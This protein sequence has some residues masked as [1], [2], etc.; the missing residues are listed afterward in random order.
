MQLSQSKKANI[1]SAFA[2]EMLQEI[3][4]LKP[5]LIQDF[6]DMF[7]PLINGFIACGLLTTIVS[8]VT[9]ALVPEFHSW[10]ALPIAL[11]INFLAACKGAALAY[12]KSPNRLAYVSFTKHTMQIKLLEFRGYEAQ[13]RLGNEDEKSEA[14][15]SLVACS[16]EIQKLIKTISTYTEQSTKFKN[17][18][19]GEKTLLSEALK[20]AEQTKQEIEATFTEFDPNLDKHPSISY[21][22]SVSDADHL[23]TTDVLSDRLIQE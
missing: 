12:S 22:K 14:W 23:K 21:E 9:I 1:D 15:T 20:T 10:I 4:R 3:E 16:D 7:M 17:L 13:M 11:V 19:N 2:N 6:K 8:I 5:L 18:T